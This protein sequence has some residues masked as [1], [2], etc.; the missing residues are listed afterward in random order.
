MTNMKITRNFYIK[1]LLK[2][3]EIFKEYPYG[4]FGCMVTLKC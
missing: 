1:I 2:K 4:I 3:K